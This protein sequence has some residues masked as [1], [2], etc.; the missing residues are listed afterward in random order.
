MRAPW[1]AEDLG[2]APWPRVVV[3][4]EPAPLP[5]RCTVTFTPVHAPL[6]ARSA[7]ALWAAAAVAIWLLL[8]GALRL[9]AWAV[10][11]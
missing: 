8:I 2:D 11:S 9:V 3:H 1:T 7:F 5:P 4:N 10:L 6:S